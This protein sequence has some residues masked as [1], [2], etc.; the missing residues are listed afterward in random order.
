VFGR[1]YVDSVQKQDFEVPTKGSPNSETS[2]L[3]DPEEPTV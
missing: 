1:Y 2:Q 3:I